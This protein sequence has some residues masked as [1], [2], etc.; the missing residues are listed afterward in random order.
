MTTLDLGAIRS[1]LVAVVKAGTARD[2]NFYPYFPPAPLLTPCGI[3]MPGEDFITYHETFSTSSAV[4]VRWELW[5]CAALGASTDAQRTVDQWL[6][7]GSG[8]TNSVIDAIEANRT[9]AVGEPAVATVHDTIVRTATTDQILLVPGD[10]N[11]YAIVGKL[12]IDTILKR[13]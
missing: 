3:L 6:S 11:S 7:S 5:M 4:T 12:S 10:P 13:G 2:S 9:L 1:A 8:Q